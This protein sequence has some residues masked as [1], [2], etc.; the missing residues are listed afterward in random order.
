M[1][2][3]LVKLLKK[4]L[5]ILFNKPYK[6]NFALKKVCLSSNLRAC[7]HT[8]SERFAD[9]D[10]FPVGGSICRRDFDKLNLVVVVWLLV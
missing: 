3:N 10:F 7:S 8:F 4:S 2:L 6:R 1:I 5:F 9:L